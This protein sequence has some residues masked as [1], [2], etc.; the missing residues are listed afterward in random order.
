MNIY[1]KGFIGAIVF[2]VLVSIMP[3]ACNTK[4]SNSSLRE[5]C[6]NTLS[7]VQ[8]ATIYDKP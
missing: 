2:T 5:K 8:C 4:E 7:A 6:R 3:S 1:T